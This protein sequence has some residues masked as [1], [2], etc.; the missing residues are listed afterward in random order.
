[1][2]VVVIWK[3]FG[4]YNKVRQKQFH[5]L[6]LR[7]L[8][9]IHDVGYQRKHLKKMKT[10]KPKLK[11]IERRLRNQ[12]GSNMDERMPVLTETDDGRVS[13]DS[14]VLFDALDTQD[15]DV[16]PYRKINKVLNL[17]DLQFREFVRRMNNV[18]GESMETMEVE[19]HIFITQFLAVYAAIIHLDPSAE[20]AAS[21]FDDIAKHGVT[22]T[23]EIPHRIFYT[24]R[25]T[26]F[27]TAEQINTILK[28]FQRTKE[29]NEE[30]EYG[31][32]YESP[33]LDETTLSSAPKVKEVPAAF[34]RSFFGLQDRGF[35]VSREEFIARY[36]KLLADATKP[37]EKLKSMVFASQLSLHGGLDVAFDN[38]CVSVNVKDRP[39]KIID[40]VTGRL[41]SG[42]MTALMGSPSSG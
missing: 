39:F 41:C 13:F 1:M 27:L 16:L 14:A 15:E 2:L 8:S 7:K 22:S 12:Y 5:A 21:L 29:F 25:L 42:T 18:A 9:G 34:R 20:D 30:Y 17:T 19:R 35:S 36:P 31:K 4:R 26:E 32:K 40:G 24:S 6:R 3:G 38:L 28:D 33:K 23:G 10:L 11:S 37:I